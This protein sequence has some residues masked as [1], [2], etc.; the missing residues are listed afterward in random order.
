MNTDRPR[1]RL[2]TALLL[3]VVAAALC[4]AVAGVAA[5][6]ETDSAFAKENLIRLHVIAHSDS[7]KD[8]DLKLLV[9]DAVLKETRAL[10]SEV[11]TKHEA[12]R[13]LLE[14]QARVVQAAKQV[15]EMQGFDYEVSLEVGAYPF[16]ERSYRGLTLPAGTYD[17]VQIRIGAAQGGNW[18]CVLFPPLCFGELEVGGSSGELA[19][20][21]PQGEVGKIA[22]RFRVVEVI[23]AANYPEQLRS[24]CQASAAGL[25]R[26]NSQ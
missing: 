24:W 2:V 23:Q 12:R 4:T 10:F 13:L 20:V 6:V 26:I 3:I 1:I 17:A 22:F 14:N 5:L 16:P 15:V 21:D 25:T 9:R 8:Q 11:N 19:H 7:P 18:W